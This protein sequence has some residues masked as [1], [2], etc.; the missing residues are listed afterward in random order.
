MCPTWSYLA[1][2]KLY[3]TKLTAGGDVITNERRSTSA[4]GIFSERGEK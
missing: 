4:Y 3:T 1:K 2:N